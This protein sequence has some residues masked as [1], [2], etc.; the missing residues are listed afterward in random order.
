MRTAT[1]T[2]SGARIS[3]GALL[4]AASIALVGCVTVPTPPAPVET[5]PSET[6]ASAET[7]AT[8]A[9]YYEDDVVGY[10]VTFPGEPD[11]QLLATAGTNRPVN[12]VSYGDPSTLALLTHGEILDHPADLRSELLGW[13]GSVGPDSVQAS[14]ADLAGLAALRAELIMPDGTEATMIVAGEGV[15][16]LRLLAIGGTAEERQEFVDS[17][18]LIDLPGRGR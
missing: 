2:I 13:A 3:L 6:P 14:S 5:A 4:I 9:G 17:F 11:V 7:P 18:E 15:R 16:F 8:A 12:V 10:A 1:T